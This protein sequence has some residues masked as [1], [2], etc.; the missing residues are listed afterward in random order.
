MKKYV[1]RPTSDEK[2]SDMQIPSWKDHHAWLDGER[3]SRMEITQGDDTRYDTRQD[4]VTSHGSF[5]S[6]A[7]REYGTGVVWSHM[8]MMLEVGGGETPPHQEESDI[9]F[10]LYA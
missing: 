9:F 7:R 1:V 6:V 3:A 5:F 8:A 2:K 10:L 4:A